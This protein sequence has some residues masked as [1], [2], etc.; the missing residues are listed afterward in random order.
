M[1]AIVNVTADGSV[2]DEL[3]F[4]FTP[5]DV[6]V[7]FRA[8]RSPAG[9]LDLGANRRRVEDLRKRLGLSKLPVMRSRNTVLWF[10]SPL[11]SFGPATY[12]A[13]GVPPLRR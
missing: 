13:T 1:R 3:E 9:V 12:D 8:E 10:E 5:D 7:Q 11:D 2:R 6:L 4:Y